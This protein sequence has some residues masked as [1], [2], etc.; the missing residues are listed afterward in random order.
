MKNINDKIEQ[1]IKFLSEI[2]MSDDSASTIIDTDVLLAKCYHEKWSEIDAY[3][4]RSRSPGTAGTSYQFVLYGKNIINVLG[5]YD[6]AL[7][8]LSL[9]AKKFSNNISGTSFK[10]LMNLLNYRGKNL[11]PES[12]GFLNAI[13]ESENHVFSTNISVYITN[14]II[15]SDTQDPLYDNIK[16]G[17]HSWL[18]KA[19]LKILD[20]GPYEYNSK[21]Y[22]KFLVSAINVLF[23]C[24]DNGEIKNLA[25]AVLN[26]MFFKYAV[27]S[28]DGKLITP[29]RR[30]QDHLSDIIRKNDEFATWALA[31]TSEV[32]DDEKASYEEMKYD[33]AFITVC[34]ICSFRPFD[35]TLDILKNKKK[36][37][38]VKSFHSNMEF[39]YNEPAFTIFSGGYEDAM[40]SFK[41]PFYMTP[42]DATVRET[43]VLLRDGSDSVN[44]LIRFIPVGGYWRLKN[45]TGV[46]KNFACGTNLTLPASF[47]PT[48]TF[49]DFSFIETEECYIALR[50]SNITFDP[51]RDLK[52]VGCIEVVDK[53]EFIDFSSFVNRV[54]S[55]NVGTSLGRFGTSTYSSTRGYDISFVTLPN[56]QGWLIK[57]VKKN[58][59]LIESE[60]ISNKLNEYLYAEDGHENQIIEDIFIVP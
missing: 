54:I 51:L 22:T 13:P 57:E 49:E 21:P 45:S 60:E 50:I 41:V 46:Y 24:V 7:I 1:E 38:W 18:V 53:S 12:W 32:P 31:Y 43:C 56:T 40:L 37:T 9:I 27:Q 39:T 48:V 33:T 47:K 35:S 3:F 58:G 28:Y 34:R 2:D 10:N 4:S 6:F 16:N 8:P 52:N 55:L 15:F 20:R 19:L 11:L 42:N 44:Q 25:R 26:R 5:D 36:T 29:Y 14:E 17:C 30:R 23:T 59:K